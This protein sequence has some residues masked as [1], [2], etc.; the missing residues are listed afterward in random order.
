MLYILGFDLKENF[1]ILSTQV[2]ITLKP[3]DFVQVFFFS[4]RPWIP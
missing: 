2:V 4:F 3:F 1:Q